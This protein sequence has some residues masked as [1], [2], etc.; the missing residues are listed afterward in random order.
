MT[1]NRFI[2]GLQAGRRRGRP[3]I[4]AELAVNDAPAFAALVASRPTAAVAADG[5]R[6]AADATG[7]LSGPACHA[8]RAPGG[9]RAWPTRGLRP[10]A[11]GPAAHR[12]RGASARAAVPRRGPAGGRGGGRATAA[13]VAAGGRPS[14][15]SSS[16]PR[17]PPAGSA[18]PR[19]GP[20]SP[21]PARSPPTRCSPRM[22]RDGHP[23]GPARGLRAR[24]R[25]ARG[26]SS[27]PAP[28]GRRP[29]RRP[30]PGQ[31]RHRAAHRRR[32]RRG[33]VVF[34]DASVDLYNAKCVR[35]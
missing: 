10:G 4:L 34:T 14:C 19:G 32:R 26:A 16:P 24:G 7:R 15:S 17:T 18:G 31:R 1:Y 27:R 5:P 25:P 20:A 12:R 21:G 11:G 9:R 23:A 29:G 13:A 2:Q 35:A 28:A 6:R 3:Q 8:D 33:A 22:S 30:R